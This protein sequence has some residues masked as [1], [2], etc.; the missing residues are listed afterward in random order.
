MIVRK[1]NAFAIQVDIWGIEDLSIELRSNN[2]ILAELAS[3][4]VAQ[5]LHDLRDSHA[6][7]YG[8]LLLEFLGSHGDYTEISDRYLHL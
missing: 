2:G 7:L 4:A 8:D 6:V 5:L 3:V 1:M